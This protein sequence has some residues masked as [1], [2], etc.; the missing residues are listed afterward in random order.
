M[1]SVSGVGDLMSPFAYYFL[2]VLVIIVAIFLIYSL[3]R[4]LIAGIK[5]DGW[6]ISRLVIAFLLAIILVIVLQTI[7][8][9]Q[10]LK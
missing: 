1:F 2:V 8:F 6:K 9:I 3:Y 7:N 10:W 4:F 5:I